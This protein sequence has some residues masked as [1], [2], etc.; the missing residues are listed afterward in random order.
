M[1]SALISLGTKKNVSGEVIN[2]GNPQEI[3]IAELAILIK[4]LT[5]S[6]SQITYLPIEQDDPKKRKPDISKAKQLLEWNPKISL[7][8]GLIKTIE[9]FKNII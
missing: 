4:K 7:K 5:N 2:I 6:S 8:E 9:Y 3:S 1:I